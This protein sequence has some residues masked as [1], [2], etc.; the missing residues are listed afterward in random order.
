MKAKEGKDGEGCKDIAKE[1]ADQLAVDHAK[2]VHNPNSVLTR[3][4]GI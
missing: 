3:S 1:M 4:P 2:G